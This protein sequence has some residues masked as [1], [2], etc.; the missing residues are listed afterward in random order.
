MGL[1]KSWASIRDNSVTTSLSRSKYFIPHPKICFQTLLGQ[2]DQCSRL[3]LVWVPIARGT[4]PTLKP[5]TL[6]NLF[7]SLSGMIT[8][9]RKILRFLRQAP[10]LNSLKIVKRVTVEITQILR[11]RRH[12]RPP[13]LTALRLT[14]AHYRQYLPKEYNYSVNKAVGA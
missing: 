7:C 11:P 14:G 4:R 9:S 1:S 3:T 2:C 5:F 6:F 13:S 12:F 8:D 10:R